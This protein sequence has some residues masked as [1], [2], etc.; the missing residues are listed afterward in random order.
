LDLG[1]RVEQSVAMLVNDIDLLRAAARRHDALNEEAVLQIAV[2]VES[3]EQADALY[4]LSRAM[5]HSTVHDEDQLRGLHDLV[6]GALAHPELVGREAG[7]EVEMRRAQAAR[8]VT[9]RATRER[10]R[11]TPRAYVLA[12]SPE[13]LARQAGLCEP[14]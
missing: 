10:I 8:F 5:G 9:A 12:H 1:A 2:H 11:T 14:T 7:N 4:L 6:R 3:V 13:D